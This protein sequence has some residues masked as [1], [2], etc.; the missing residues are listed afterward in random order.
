[1]SE[2]T[3]ISVESMQSMVRAIGSKALAE[4]LVTGIDQCEQEGRP[5]SQLQQVN[6]ATMTIMAYGDL[7]D[8]MN[9]GIITEAVLQ[10]EACG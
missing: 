7:L 2:P 8:D 1:M 10:R 5:L 6:L 3:T 9:V 4:A